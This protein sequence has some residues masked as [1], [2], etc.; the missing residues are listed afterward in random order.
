MG[1]ADYYVMMAFPRRPKTAAGHKKWSDSVRPTAPEGDSN[2]SESK[3]KAVTLSF[4]C[5]T[6]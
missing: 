4:F 6:I 3:V 1:A 5:L 2:F